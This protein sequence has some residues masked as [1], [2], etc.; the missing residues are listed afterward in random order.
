MKK[1]RKVQYRQVIHAEG[2]ALLGQRC[3]ALMKGVCILHIFESVQIARVKQTQDY[4][5]LKHALL[6]RFNL[7]DKVSSRN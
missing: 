4:D 1:T 5:I 2:L 6:R 7:T 3:H